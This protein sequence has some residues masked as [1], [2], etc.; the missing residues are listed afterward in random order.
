MSPSNLFKTTLYTAYFDHHWWSSGVLKLFVETAVLAFCASYVRC[1]VP[2]YYLL[3][4]LHTYSLT[5]PSSWGAANCA[6]TRELSSILWNSKVQYRVY[7]SLPV[8]PILSHINPIHTTSS[9]PIS[10]RSILILST[11][12]SLGLPSGLVP[13][14]FPT[15]SY[16]HSS[17]PHS[18]YMS[19]PSHLPRLDHSNYTWRWVQVMKLLIMQFSL[20]SCHF[21]SLWYKNF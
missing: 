10:L 11:H 5:E 14:G 19:C 1:A 21:I 12:L 20:T 7:K 8:V 15:I 6:A 3:N 17:S 18:C 9:H 16:M 2:V 13:S 4:Y